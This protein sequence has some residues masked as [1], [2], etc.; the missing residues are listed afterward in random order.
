[1]RLNVEVRN[2]TTGARLD[3]DRQGLNDGLVLLRMW[4]EAPVQQLMSK[5]AKEVQLVLELAKT[6]ELCT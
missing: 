2:A 5:E 1:V 6:T 4:Q 3:C